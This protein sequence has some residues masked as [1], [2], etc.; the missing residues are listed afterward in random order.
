MAETYNKNKYLLQNTKIFAISNIATKLISFLLIPLYTHCLST[1]EYGIIDLLFTITSVLL[2]VFTFNIAESIYRFSMDKNTNKNKIFNIGIIS[3]LFCCII[4]LLLIPIF[5]F[6]PQY[7]EYKIYVYFLLNT[8]ALFTIT[9]A[10]LKGKEK[11]VEYSVGNILNSFLVIIFNIIMLKFLEMGIKGYFIA[12]ITSYLI[13]SLYCIFSNL[14][15]SKVQLSNFNNKLFL[16]MIKYSIILIPNSFLWWI[17]DSSDRIM[18]SY[19]SGSSENGLYAISYKI[20]AILFAIAGIFNQAWVFS[21]I[22]EKENSDNEIFANKIFEILILF[23]VLIAMLILIFVKPLFKL[24]LA[25]EYFGAWKYVPFLLVGSLF[26]VLGNF[27]SA[28]Y[29]TYKDSKG[30][31]LSSFFA[32][33]VNIILNFIFIPKFKAYGAAFATGTS[34]FLVFIY[35]FIDTQKYLK[36]SIKREYIFLIFVLI[37]M[38]MLL[39][40]DSFWSEILLSICLLGCLFIYRKKIII[41][42]KKVLSNMR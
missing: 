3:L 5:S 11:L 26:L 25:D 24:I 27:I 39:Y 41:I 42:I 38:S 12:F 6:F 35:M 40:M 36:V 15:D 21:A 33:I 13:S 23:M 17:I 30:L 8:S 18:I 29:N 16:Q 20:P 34:Y 32:A 7:S 14:K 19:F 28:S 2:P 37:I 31:L 1:S 4:S 10:N 9:S 22:K